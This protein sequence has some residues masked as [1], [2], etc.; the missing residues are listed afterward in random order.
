M[1]MSKTKIDE[2]FTVEEVDANTFVISEYHHWE[3]THCYLLIGEERALLI[4]T[5]LGIGNIYE[6]V[7]KFT[8]KPI[9]VIATHIHS[10]HIGGHQYFSE[11]YV[12]EA[13]LDW[14]TGNF[15]LPLEMVKK[16]ILE[17]NWLPADFDINHYEIFSGQP[18]RIL[19]DNDK[20][21]LG[22]R[23]V[24]VLHTPGHSP[25]HICFFE[26]VTDP[27]AYL[28]SV[29]KVA[30]LPVKKVLP[31]HHDLDISEKMIGAVLTAFTV[32]E[33]EGKLR[34]GSGITEYQDFS[35]HL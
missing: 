15:P 28:A 30:K 16:T 4:D 8:D 2:W 17:A 21:D 32:L 35:I 9:I 26:E 7:I 5:G 27:V 31:G 34:H 3:E 20:I 12:H 23:V 19:Q 25:G 10:D 18:T 22:G 13:E 6:Q 14:I 11:F 1:K 24:Q 33:A 29:E